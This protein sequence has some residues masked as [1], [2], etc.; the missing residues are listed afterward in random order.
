MPMNSMRIESVDHGG[1]VLE[2]GDT[3]AGDGAAK[4][5]AHGAFFDFLCH[6]IAGDRAR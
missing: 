6:E 4:E 1:E 2:Q 5:H 3:D